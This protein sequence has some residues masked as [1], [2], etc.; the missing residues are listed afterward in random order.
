MSSSSKDSNPRGTSALALIKVALS[1]DVDARIRC[2]TYVTHGSS[3][4]ASSG[5]LLF[6]VDFATVFESMDRDSLWRIMAADGMP[7]KLMLIKAYYTSTKMKFRA[8][9]DDSMPFEI[10]PGVRQE[11]A[12]CLLIV[13]VSF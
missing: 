4:G 12:L 1:L 6:F 10:Y 2:T 5:L 13:T 3:V 7:F 8:S 9:G 11:C